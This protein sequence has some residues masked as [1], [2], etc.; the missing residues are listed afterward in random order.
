VTDAIDLDT[1]PTLT[2]P[3]EH[4]ELCGHPMPEGVIGWCADC[5]GNEV[6]SRAEAYEDFYSWGGWRRAFGEYTDEEWELVKH[7]TTC[8]RTPS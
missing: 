5:P 3:N 6:T 4:C 1:E 7:R 2:V 8:G